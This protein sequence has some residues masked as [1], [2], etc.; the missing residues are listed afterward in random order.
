MDHGAQP[1]HNPAQGPGYETTDVRVRPILIAGVGVVIMTV[2]VVMFLKGMIFTLEREEPPTRFVEEDAKLE[3]N[4]FTNL[5]AQ[6]DRLRQE[7]TDG[8]G[9]YAYDKKTGVVVIPINRAI[10][11]IVERGVPKGKGPKTEAE[12]IR[13]DEE[14]KAK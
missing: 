14:K 9:Q 1:A 3:D 8:L 7:E 6:K 4:P 13:R 10:D 5:Y 11:L 2:L 12:I